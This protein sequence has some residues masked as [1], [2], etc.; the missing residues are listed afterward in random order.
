METKKNIIALRTY[1]K[2]HSEKIACSKCGMVLKSSRK[3]IV[4]DNN[5]AFCEYCYKN[6]LFPN[7]HE[8]CLEIVN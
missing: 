3:G 6:L 7:L 1:E 2:S 4:G 8:N 5:I